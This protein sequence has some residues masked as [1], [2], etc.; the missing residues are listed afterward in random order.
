MYFGVNAIWIAISG[1]KM[2]FCSFCLR[3]EKRS[4][5]R[6]G[7]IENFVIYFGF[8]I[9]KRRWNDLKFDIVELEIGVMRP[10]IELNWYSQIFTLKLRFIAPKN[11]PKSLFPPFSI[12]VL[13]IPILVTEF[14]R[15]WQAHK[16]KN[17]GFVDGTEE[18]GF[19]TTHPS[20]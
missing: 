15:F 2:L 4:S 1:L 18:R 13:I 6:P 16:I 5:C 8:L 14:I 19:S 7:L 17:Q 12:K 11:A 10:E 20:L 9:G 3:L